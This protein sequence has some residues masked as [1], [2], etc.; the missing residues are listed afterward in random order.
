MPLT[1]DEIRLLL[2]MLDYAD[3]YTPE[4][5]KRHAAQEFAEADGLLARLRNQQG[6]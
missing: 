5:V 2:L 6:E 1:Q 3:K 4:G